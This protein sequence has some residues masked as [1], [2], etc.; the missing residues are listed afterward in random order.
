MFTATIR[1]RWA[2]CQLQELK[3]LKSTRPS[4][5]KDALYNLPETLH[6]TYERM[7]TGIDG[8]SREDALVLL[9]WLAYARSPPSLG[10]LIEARIIDPAE[11]G[12]VDVDDRGGLED[13]LDILCGLITVEGDDDGGAT[14]VSGLDD[15]DPK[16]RDQS[17]AHSIRK[18]KEARVRLAHFSVQEYLESEHILRSDARMF[19]LESAKDHRFLAQSCLTYLLHYSSSEEKASDKRDLT[20]F[21]LLEYAAQSWFYHSSLQRSGDVSR[22]VFL[23]APESA[24]YDWLLVHQPDWPLQLPFTRDRD[25]GTDLYYACFLGLGDVADRLL[26]VGADVNALGGQHGYALQ[27]ASYAGHH[28]IAKM[29]IAEG[30]NVNAIGGEC[31]SALGAATAKGYMEL[32]EMLVANGADVNTGGGMFHGDPLFT[33]LSGRHEDIAEMLIKNGADVNSQKSAFNKTPLLAAIDHNCSRIVKILTTLGV[34][35]ITVHTR[36]ALPQPHVPA[37]VTALLARRLCCI[38]V[39]VPLHLLSF[40]DLAS[41]IIQPRLNNLLRFQRAANHL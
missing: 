10:E 17:T 20:A 16:R 27:A 40:C 30:A 38:C 8:R 15:A 31:G 14:K 13:S 12:S 36:V 32:A 23:L 25:V 5:V 1:F 26:S 11:D 37:Q 19:Y 4:H 9:R 34:D 28:K 39:S 35:C 24:M 18:V 29:L 2:Y 41:V 6:E 33:A 22:E 3:R 21:P 7:L